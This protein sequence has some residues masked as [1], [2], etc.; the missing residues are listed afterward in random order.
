ML[1]ESG[2]GRKG[3]WIKASYSKMGQ[4]VFPEIIE[5][6][7]SPF[8]SGCTFFDVAFQLN[9]KSDIIGGRTCGK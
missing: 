6:H 2:I 4:I 8:D 7:E 3:R 9:K 1:A 5:C